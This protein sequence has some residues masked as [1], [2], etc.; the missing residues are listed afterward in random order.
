MWNSQS[1]ECR[2]TSP[3]REILTRL[4]RPCVHNAP[5]KIVE[6]SPA[7]YIYGKAA[8]RSPKDQAEW[9]HPGPCLV[10][11]W[12]GASRTMR[13]CCWPRDISSPPRAAAHTTLPRRKAGMKLN[14]K[15]NIRGSIHGNVLSVSVLG[16]F[17]HFVCYWLAKPLTF[18]RAGKSS[19]K[20]NSWNK[21]LVLEFPVTLNFKLI[22]LYTITKHSIWRT[23][24]GS[25]SLENIDN[26]M[27]LFSLK[28]GF[29]TWGTCI[30]S[31]TSA[32]MQGYI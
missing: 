19:P 29:P 28:Q 10:P 5:G 17:S 20:L 8:K 31:G 21:N 27:D 18:T 11:S 6:A 1:S 4:V 25:Y 2:T 15:I 9:L 23:E 12:C 30:P 14:E 24:M 32:Y 3:N 26:V 7:G 13:D 16:A 22:A